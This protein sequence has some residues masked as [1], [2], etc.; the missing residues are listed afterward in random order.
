MDNVDTAP[1]AASPDSMV[2]PW[3]WIS[4]SN[5]L[6]TDRYLC[7]ELLFITRNGIIMSALY[8]TVLMSTK[9]D[10][11]YYNRKKVFQGGRSR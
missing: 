7:M 1:A 8:G 6:L 9:F 4:Q 5:Y 11:Y 10:V 2:E 3:G